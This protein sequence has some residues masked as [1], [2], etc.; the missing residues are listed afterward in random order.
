MI[1]KA[2]IDKI[3]KMEI[4]RGEDEEGWRELGKKLGKGKVDLESFGIMAEE[5]LDLVEAYRRSPGTVEEVKERILTGCTKLGKKINLGKEFDLYF[6]DLIKR[7]ELYLGLAVGREEMYEKPENSNYTLGPDGVLRRVLTED[8]FYWLLFARHALVVPMAMQKALKE[9]HVVLA[10]VS[11]GAR[12]MDALV[13]MG[14]G[15]A[16]M[17]DDARVELSNITRMGLDLGDLGKTKVGAV[18]ERLWKVNPYLRLGLHKRRADLEDVKLAKKKNSLVFMEEIDGLKAKIELRQKAEEL[19]VGML[20]A[21]DVHGRAYAA[22]DTPGSGL[23]FGRRFSEEDEKWI[24]AGHANPGID[25]QEF[26][27]QVGLIIGD[28]NMDPRLASYLLAAAF[29][30]APLMLPQTAETA[31]E[32][33]ALNSQILGKLAGGEKLDGG[34]YY[35]GRVSINDSKKNV[36]KAWSEVI[37]R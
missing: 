27:R 23:R 7:R 12:T 24:L 30:A 11:V 22:Y 32:T 33:A 34:E 21:T 8:R 19:G 25:P 17:F 1:Q 26:I 31:L 35:P 36:L 15:S 37:S 3:P 14:L 10:G 4:I 29:G 9:G 16:D 28:R 13:R 18:A 5:F 20:M 6:K 2:G